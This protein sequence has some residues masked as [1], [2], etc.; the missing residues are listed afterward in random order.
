MGRFVETAR[1]EVY[2]V[3]VTEEEKDLFL[4]LS[5]QETRE[6]LRKAAEGKGK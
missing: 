1:Y 5:S 2:S 4:R 6:A 3:R